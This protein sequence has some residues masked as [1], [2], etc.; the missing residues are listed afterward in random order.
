VAADPSTGGEPADADNR[1]TFERFEDLTRR[2]L[3]VP[4]SEVDA[5]LKKDK[6]KRQR[7]PRTD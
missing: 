2:L 4:K 5:K 6:A 7:A 1:S 3:S